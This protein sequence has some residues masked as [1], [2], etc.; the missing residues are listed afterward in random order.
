LTDAIFADNGAI[1]S[2]QAETLFFDNKYITRR[3]RAEDFT[4]LEQSAESE[5]APIYLGDGNSAGLNYG[6][7]GHAPVH[8]SRTGAGSG[9]TRAKLF[10]GYTFDDAKM[11]NG[12]DLPRIYVRNPRKSAQTDQWVR[13]HLEGNPNAQYVGPGTFTGM[14]TSQHPFWVLG[15]TERAHIFSP[16]KARI[17]TACGGVYKIYGIAPLDQSELAC[18]VYEAEWSG[19][20]WRPVGGLIARTVVQRDRAW[21]TGSNR[22]I[23]RAPFPEPFLVTP[24]KS[25]M[26]IFSHS[27]EYPFNDDLTS[28]YT[29]FLLQGGGQGSP[30][31]WR[32]TVGPDTSW[33][34]EPT[35]R[36]GFSLY[37]LGEADSTYFYRGSGS[38]VSAS[39][40]QM[41]TRDHEDYA[42]AGLPLPRLDNRFQFRVSM[43]G[44]ED[45]DGSITGSAGQLLSNPADIVRF[46]LESSDFGVN[47]SSGDIDSA[48]HTDARDR[49]ENQG[50]HSSFGAALTT[51]IDAETF[52][53]Q[54]CEQWRL[55]YYRG[56]A[57]KH[58]IHYPLPLSAK[59]TAATLLE[60]RLRDEFRV[61]QY[62]ENPLDSIAN[63]YEILYAPDPLDTQDDPALNRRGGQ[64]FKG[65]IYLNEDETNIDGESTRV[66]EAATSSGIYG[67]RYL[68]R[69]FWTHSL[70][71]A[72]IKV[73]K[74][75]FDRWSEKQQQTVIKIPARNY[76]ST[77]GPLDKVV[78]THTAY[79]RGN[80]H[81][82]FKHGED[83][84]DSDGVPQTTLDTNSFT[85]E[86]IRI[87]E[88]GAYM[89]IT[90]ET[91]SEFSYASA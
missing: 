76:Y 67:R 50:L 68:R 38:S 57:G 32:H 80:V 91:V 58:F 9:M 85:G 44:L 5:I 86:A 77:I 27:F 88:Q 23:F 87:E 69:R 64:K 1:L 26:A 43:S 31:L 65:V 29:V 66:T 30:S 34:Y 51:Q 48:A 71:S 17:I 70:R 82:Q 61:E 63:D 19:A 59:S 49:L 75:L 12:S 47:V 14:I 3:F 62:R 39:Y 73:F 35:I 25:Y 6:S 54:V 7:I 42:Q 37:A 24:D 28:G 13:L 45:T 46:V 8:D 55:V 2:L 74:Y 89:Y 60:E 21:L 52:I 16:G 72:V 18:E 83:E 20:T 78:A 90:L 40:L 84:F 36:L 15:H 4:E 41:Q 33:H 81:G 53:R 79:K 11:K 56:R 10:A 22:R